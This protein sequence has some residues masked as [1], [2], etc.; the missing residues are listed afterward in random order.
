[1]KQ[2]HLLFVLVPLVIFVSSLVVAQV[3][4]PPTPPPVPLPF[5]ERINAALT[6]F[7]SWIGTGGVV[8]ILALL[9]RI[10]KSFPN[11]AI[12]ILLA[13]GNTLGL[14]ATCLHKIAEA[15]GGVAWTGPGGIAYAG[16]WGTFSGILTG[17]VA[18]MLVSGM[19]VLQRVLWE[20]FVRHAVAPST[21]PPV[22]AGQV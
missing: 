10:W 13:I 3:A 20:K 5:F 6:V 18:A 22:E 7:L 12:P 2:R 9:A 4:P 19:G 14:V 21:V 1:M 15:L 17:G 8:F 16:L 11:K